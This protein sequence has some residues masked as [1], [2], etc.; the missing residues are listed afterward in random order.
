MVLLGYP[1]RY[2]RG[3]EDHS[4]LNHDQLSWLSVVKFVFCPLFEKL[5]FFL[6]SSDNSTNT[7]LH[8]H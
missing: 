7:H 6:L 8:I 4:P 2:H 5:A 3:S 1:I